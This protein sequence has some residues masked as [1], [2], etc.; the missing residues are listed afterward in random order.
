MDVLQSPCLAATARATACRGPLIADR[1]GAPGGRCRPCAIPRPAPRRAASCPSSRAP[2][3]LTSWAPL[4]SFACHTQNTAPDGSANTP[5]RPAPSTS[6]GS[7]STLPLASSPSRRRC[8][9]CRPRHSCSIPAS[10]GVSSGWDP[11]AAT[12]RPAAALRSTDRVSRRACGSRTPTRT[13]RR[14]SRPRPTRPAD[15]CRPS[16]G[17]RADI[18]LAQAPLLPSRLIAWEQPRVALRPRSGLNAK[19]RPAATR[20]A[21]SSRT[22]RGPDYSGTTLTAFGPLSPASAS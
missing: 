5:M 6:N 4:C 21:F 16:T 2:G 14:R 13:G 19:E 12:S 18:R 7:V 8:R 17:P 11:T 9:R 1:F 22:P 10:G 20:G 15:R 3:S